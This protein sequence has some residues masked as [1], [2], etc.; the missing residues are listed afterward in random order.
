MIQPFPLTFITRNK[1]KP[2][3]IFNEY[4]ENNRQNPAEYPI[5][6]ATEALSTKTKA[7]TLPHFGPLE[8]R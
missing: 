6:K 4:I 1:S 3:Y 5:R 2:T 7:G 8:N